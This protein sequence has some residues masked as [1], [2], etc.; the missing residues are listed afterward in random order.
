MM[1]FDFRTQFVSIEQLRL[2][3]LLRL[4]V[5]GACWEATVKSQAEKDA[6]M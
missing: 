3:K 1:R 2:L 6:N 4:G 5:P